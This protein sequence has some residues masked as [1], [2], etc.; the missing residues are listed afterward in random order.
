[1]PPLPFY[2]YAQCA[3]ELSFIPP[4]P[5]NGLSIAQNLGCLALIAVGIRLLAFAFLWASFAS[6]ALPAWLARP[7]RRIRDALAFVFC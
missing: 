4:P 2:A 1:M 6:F 7:A 3:A 5:A